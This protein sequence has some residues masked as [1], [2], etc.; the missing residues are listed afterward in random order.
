[1]RKQP[2]GSAG[3]DKYVCDGNGG[4]DRRG[5]LHGE[6]A[7]NFNFKKLSTFISN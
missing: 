3:R 7:F 6:C 4:Q 2:R 5:R 1:M